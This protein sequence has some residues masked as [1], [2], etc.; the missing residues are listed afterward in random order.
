MSETNDQTTWYSSWFDTPYYHILYRDRDYIEAGHFMKRLT[1]RLELDQQAHIL[2]LAC[3]RGRH[4][5]FLNRLGYRVTGVDLSESSIAFAKAKLDHIKSGNLELGELGTGKVQL[6]RIQFAVHNMTQPYP[7]KFDAIFNLFTS[8]GYFDNPDDNLKTIQ[9]IKQSL[10]LDGYGVIDFFNS[11]KV[12]ENL[13]PYDEK[14]EKGITFKQS[15]RFEGSHIYK[16][17]RFEEDGNKFH[18]TERV[19]ALTLEDFKSYFATAGL[20]LVATYGD[21]QLEPFN[22]KT[23]DRLILVFQIAKAS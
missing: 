18:F 10:K 11:H 4:S 6:D 15:R 20:Q 17:I 19:Q 5:I 3:G 22:K 1:Q 21:Y 2:D 8:F 23:S 16:E 7:E 12:I 13:V 14:T 9:A